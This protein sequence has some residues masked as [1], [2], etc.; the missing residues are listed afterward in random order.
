MADSQ[1][2]DEVIF[3]DTLVNKAK[4]NFKTKIGKE[5]SAVGTKLSVFNDKTIH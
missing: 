2:T 5:Y 1:S 3:C 4:H